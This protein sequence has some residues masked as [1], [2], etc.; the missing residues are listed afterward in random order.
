M[1]REVRDREVLMNAKKNLDADLIQI[2][3]EVDH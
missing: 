2:S 1:E 3:D